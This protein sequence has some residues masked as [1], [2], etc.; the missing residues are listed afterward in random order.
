MV[1]AAT[2]GVKKKPQNR[3]SKACQT[4]HRRRV[5]CDASKSGLPCSRCKQ[6]GV[7]DC[8]FIVSKRGTYDRKKRKLSNSGSSS[9][10][11]TSPQPAAAAPLSVASV[12]CVERDGTD[13]P[14]WSTAFDQ[15][16]NNAVDNKQVVKSE[17]ITY[18]GESFLLS[19]VMGNDPKS[20]R[21]ALKMH[22]AGPSSDSKPNHPDHLEEQELALMEA[23]GGFTRC[24]PHIEQ[25]LIAVFFE[26]FYP[27][28]PIVDRQKFMQ[29]YNDGKVPWILLHAVCFISSIY[30][31]FS[32]LHAAGFADRNQA[33]STFYSRGKILFDLNYERNKLVSIQTQLLFSFNVGRPNDLYYTHTWIGIAVSTGE[34]IG[35]HRT[36][37]CSGVEDWERGLLKRIWW[38]LFVRDASIAALF[39]RPPR[40]N[41][42]HC[43]AEELTLADFDDDTPD[44]ASSYYQ[45]Q[46][47]KLT[48]ILREIANCR[49]NLNFPEGRID[50]LHQKLKDWK[51]QLPVQLR[52]DDHNGLYR[53]SNSNI[54][55][56]ALEMIY[57]HHLIHLHLQDSKFFSSSSERSHSYSIVEVATKRIT[58]IARYLVT[59]SLATTMP[60]E[61]YPALFAA[62]VV[63]YSQLRSGDS[64]RADLARAQ[65]DICQ[66]VLREISDFWDSAPWIMHL[67]EVLVTKLESNEI[68]TDSFKSDEDHS[69]GKVLADAGL[70]EFISF[71]NA[72]QGNQDTPLLASDDLDSLLSNITE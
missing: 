30:A 44:Q 43:D 23:K 64:T 11:T 26:K 53:N 65:L 52:W 31:P 20:G 58:T 62:Q 4:C 35:L 7:P 50:I 72:W 56:L 1:T 66:M 63:L 61:C 18:L 19:L 32:L 28:Y 68:F 49:W 42:E 67:F 57:N 5:K 36:I 9:S 59:S 39:G 27:I 14:T 51:N 3:A 6:D 25:A 60:Q 24:V 47:V 34:T 38:A 12:G 29:D 37:S 46:I 55:S 8:Q 48:W 13:T 41:P 17:A 40:I 33:R 10:T 16:L 71:L 22:H 15:V 70:N 2:S 21:S 45:V 54:Y 69:P